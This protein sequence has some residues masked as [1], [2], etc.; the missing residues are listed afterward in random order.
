MYSLKE[1]KEI[2]DPVLEKFLDKRLEEFSVNTSDSFIKDFV[3]YS[4]DLVM[5]G[6]KR[7]RPYIAYVMYSAMGGKDTENA[8][9]LFISLEIFHS[10]ALMHDDIMDKADTR[11]GVSTIH[12]YVLKKLRESERSADIENVSKAQAILVGDL[13]F[14]WVMEIFLGNKNFPVENI[15]KAQDYFYKMVDEVVLGQMIDIDITTRENA[16]EKL[17]SEKTR[18]KTSRY[19]FVRPMQIGAHLA[20][21]KNDMDDFCENLGTKLGIAFQM[22]DDL[23]DIIGD[24]KILEKSIL[25]DIADRQHTFFTNYIFEKGTKEQK[26]KLTG[27]F[28]K[29][30]NEEEQKE[31]IKIFIESGAVEQGKKLILEELEDAKK[32]ISDSSLGQEYKNICFDLVKIMEERQS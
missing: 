4:K 22:Q 12:S 21:P 25:R 14:S 19:T 3:F 31:V 30:L 18:L 32:I 7:I 9:K 24:P 5:A 1:F 29:E 2:F 27:Y 23:L 11:H 8:I 26:E 17:I 28:G 15:T 16:I 20:D 6:G 10:F 13:F